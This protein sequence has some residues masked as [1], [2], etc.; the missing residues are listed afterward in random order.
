[1]EEEKMAF[2]KNCGTQLGDGDL[3]CPNCGTKNSAPNPDAGRQT[4]ENQTADVS[5]QTAENQFADVSRQ[6]TENQTADVSRQ[7]QEDNSAD[8]LKEEVKQEFSND[9]FVISNDKITV[10]TQENGNSGEKTKRNKKS[11]KKLVVGLG[12]TA[13]VLAVALIAVLIIK[14]MSKKV[15]VDGCIKVEVSGYDTQGYAEISLDEEAF[16]ECIAEAKGEELKKEGSKGRER[17]KEDW[18]YD[19]LKELIELT[20]DKETELSNGDEI[21]IEISFDNEEAKEYGLKFTGETYT[22]TVKGLEEL[23][24]IDIF[25]DLVVEFK[26]TAPDAYVS[27]FYDDGDGELAYY[28][29]LS[30]DKKNGLDIGDVITI[31]FEGEDELLKQGYKLT[32][33]SKEYT[34]ENVDKY[35]GSVEEL[36]AT[37]FGEIKDDAKSYIEAYFAKNIDYLGY[38]NLSYEGSY[39]LTKKNDQSYG[40]QNAVYVIFSVQVSS[41][42]TFSRTN[43]SRGEVEGAPKFATQTVYMPVG[44][45]N[46]MIKADGSIYYPSNQGIF[47]DTELEYNG[48]YEV[49]GCS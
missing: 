28:G 47:G 48:W 39:V 41:K 36:T 13:A 23:K 18:E 8:I 25:E 17:Q 34:C 35:V 46:V 24:E 30:V 37:G 19:E 5:R 16:L 15:A 1:M 26:G 45:S 32:T 21:V 14:N 43:E 9:V 49:E 3:F 7:I 12:I 6:T 4:T 44:Y 11:G 20:A 38:E 2:C 42:E 22:Y 27:Y 31:T 10:K 40:S 29:T 33:T